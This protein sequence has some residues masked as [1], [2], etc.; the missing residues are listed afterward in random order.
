MSS[1]ICFKIPNKSAVSSV[2]TNTVVAKLILEKSKFGS[3]ALITAHVAAICV[4]PA[5]IIGISEPK[6]RPAIAGIVGSPTAP[7]ACIASASPGVIPAF[8]NP[9]STT[10]DLR[11]CGL[12]GILP[13][14]FSFAS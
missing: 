12:C 2:A 10:F 6:T 13:L 5:K 3:N 9:S 8:F 14:T 1:S 11:S 7:I 4:P